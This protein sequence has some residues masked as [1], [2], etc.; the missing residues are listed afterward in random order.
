MMLLL[1][2]RR[3]AFSRSARTSSPAIRPNPEVVEMV[4]APVVSSNVRFMP[5]SSA[6]NRWSKSSPIRSVADSVALSLKSSSKAMDMRLM[7]SGASS[8]FCA[9]KMSV[10][11]AGERVPA[12]APCPSLATI[13]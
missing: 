8:N 5:T 1:G 11:T 9:V 6:V 4:M 2:M 3:V 12:I 13:E 10:K 7:V